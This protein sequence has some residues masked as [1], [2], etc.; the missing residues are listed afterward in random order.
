M[1]KKGNKQ[2]CFGRKFTL[3]IAIGLALVFVYLGQPL[4]G[5]CAE[6]QGKTGWALPH[7]YPDKFDGTG[8]V[9]R[10]TVDEIVIDDFLYRLSPN[11]GYAT[12]TREHA[13]RA[14]FGVGNRVGYVTNPRHEIISL[15]LIE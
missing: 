14:W 8:R 2:F 1:E 5:M 15:W 6:T 4:T 3:L 12:P 9:G 11:A 10:I 13:L 7:Y